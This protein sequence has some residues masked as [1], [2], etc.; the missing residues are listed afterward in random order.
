MAMA[1]VSHPDASPQIIG[2]EYF[3]DESQTGFISPDGWDGGP[4]PPPPGD[5][6]FECIRE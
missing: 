4:W 5:S 1:A 2:G 6:L 3:A